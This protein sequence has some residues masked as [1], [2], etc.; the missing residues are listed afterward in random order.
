[1]NI[2]LS[3]QDKEVVY[4]YF[5]V[6]YDVFRIKKKD[7]KSYIYS[8]ILLQFSNEEDLLAV[9]DDAYDMKDAAYCWDWDFE[10][11][12]MTLYTESERCFRDCCEQLNKCEIYQFKY[13]SFKL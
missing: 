7:V 12:S 2:E 5:S 1:M 8:K 4:G 10:K 6:N 3:E 9:V 11:L 13:D